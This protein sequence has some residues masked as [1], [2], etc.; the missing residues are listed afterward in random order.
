MRQIGSVK[1]WATV[2]VAAAI[3]IVGV[4]TAQSLGTAGL[5]AKRPAADSA[6]AKAQVEETSYEI[7]PSPAIEPNP[8]FFIGVGD[9][10]NGSYEEPQRH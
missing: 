6:P 9:G 8:K 5:T 3:A 7:T 4:L 2:G 10:S 1:I